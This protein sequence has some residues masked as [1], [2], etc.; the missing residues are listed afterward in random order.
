MVALGVWA[1]WGEFFGLFGW[2]VCGGCLR[3]MFVGLFVKVI[4]FTKNCFKF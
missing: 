3:G 4:R 1:D 2:V